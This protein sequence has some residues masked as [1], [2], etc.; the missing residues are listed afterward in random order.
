MK[1]WC[2]FVIWLAATL[3]ALGCQATRPTKAELLQQNAVLE[4]KVQEQAARIQQCQQ[5]FRAVGKLLW[6]KDRMI[7]SLRAELTEKKV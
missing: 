3:A 4:A 1:F 6:L 2:I 5:L 7:E